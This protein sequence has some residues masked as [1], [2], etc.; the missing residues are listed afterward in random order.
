M[1]ELYY[2]YLE[3]CRNFNELNNLPEKG[4]EWHHTLPQCLLGDQPF[5]LWLT[6]E[7]HAIA[8]VLQSELFGTCCVFGW[9]KKLLPDKLKPLFS[10]W[11]GWLLNRSVNSKPRSKQHKRNISRA[12]KGKTKSAEHR[13]NQSLAVRG[14]PRP[15]FLGEGHGMFGRNHSKSTLEK[16]SAATTGQLHW[17]NSQ[18]K[19][20]RSTE[21]PGPEWQRGRKWRP[22]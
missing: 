6:K 13:R 21:C 12:L 11:Q 1:D 17:V 7:Q 9:M 2:G 8:S 3:G 22:Q 20:C 14:V 4:W 19:T 15:H 18:G 10:K 5:G 16:M